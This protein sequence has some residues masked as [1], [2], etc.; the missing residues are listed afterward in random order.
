LAVALVQTVTNLSIG[1]VYLP[2]IKTV[3]TFFLRQIM[4]GEKKVRIHF[5]LLLQ[6]QLIWGFS[7]FA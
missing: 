7:N 2:P 3:D 4:T 6:K 5:G 1:N